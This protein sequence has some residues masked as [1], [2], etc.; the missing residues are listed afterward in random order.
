MTNTDIQGSKQPL[1]V[2]SILSQ[3]FSIFA[4]NFVKVMALGFAGAFLGFI[5]NSLFLGFGVAVG[6]AEPD[7]A[8]MGAFWVG[9]LFSTLIGMVIYGLVTALL[10]L[11]AYDAKRGKS[12]TLGTYFM[13]ALPAVVPIALMMIVVTILASIGAIALLVG[14]FWVYAVFYVMAPAAVIERA[15][16]GAL[17]RS[18]QLTK[19]YRWPIVGLFIVMIII[20][21]LVQVVAGFLVGL[22]ATVATS[23]VGMAVVGVLFALLGAIGYAIAGIA[24]ALVYARLREIKEGV[25]VDDIAKVFD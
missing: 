1:G 3:T 10:V 11:L 14:M 22:L 18:A 12:N 20:T 17:G 19:E 25:A 8:N 16:F 2:G 23:V 13:V 4:S 21:L 6:T 9:T 24:I 7:I 5:V 15:G